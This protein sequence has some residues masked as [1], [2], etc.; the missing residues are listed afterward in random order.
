MSL[1]S[2][3]LRPL[4]V[5]HLKTAYGEL[6]DLQER[7]V[8]DF[9]D[10]RGAGNIRNSILEVHRYPPAPDELDILQRFSS[11]APTSSAR[12]PKRPLELPS[13][14]SHSYPTPSSQRIHREIPSIEGWDAE[15]IPSSERTKRHRT[16]ESKPHGTFAGHP[17][18][19]IPDSPLARDSTS[20]RGAFAGAIP[21]SAKAESPELRA[22]DPQ[23]VEK[24]DVARAEESTQTKRTKAKRA[25]LKAKTKAR[26][27]AKAEAGAKANTEA[28]ERKV[29]EENRARDEAR[30]L[31]DSE[32]KDAQK[33]VLPP[34]TAQGTATAIK[35]QAQQRIVEQEAR[36]L[37]SQRSMTPRMPGSSVTK[38]SS[39]MAS[40]RS[41]PTSNTD[42]PLRSALR[43]T[44]S[45][46]HRSVSS[47][48]FDASKPPSKT[49]TQI[50]VPKKASGREITKTPAKIGK[51]QTK[52]IV[53]REPKKLKARAV[54]PPVKPTQAAP[55]QAIVISDS[56]ASEE[57]CWQTGNA[58]A[59]PSSRKPMLPIVSQKTKPA[60]VQVLVT[61]PGIR[62]KKTQVD[63]TVAPAAL[64]RRNS[65]LDTAPMPK[66]ITRSPAQILSE[67]IS[68][69]SD[70]EKDLHAP[71]SKVLSGTK[72][73]TRVLGT[74]K[75]LSKD[76]YEVVKQPEDHLTG[77]APPQSITQ[78]PPSQ[79]RRII[80]AIADS[81]HINEAAD[82][83]LQLESQRFIPDSCVDM[84][85]SIPSVAPGDAII[86]QGLDRT[87]RLPNGIRH[88]YAADFP[89]LSVLQK[90]PRAVTPKAKP[91]MNLNSSQSVGDSPV[92][93]FEPDH[94]SS[95]GDEGSSNSDGEE[96][97][98][99]RPPQL[100]PPKPYPRV[101]K[102]AESR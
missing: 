68:I 70:S 99:R 41:S 71:T 27:K 45:S 64:P 84:A 4:K 34:R 51:V 16:H 53:T 80:P 85:S 91:K 61:P 97:I 94:S 96:D 75:K 39:L 81:E 89:K 7:V 93:K 67:T 50:P 100:V 30:K 44:P 22:S 82:R 52:L 79:S 49:P 18:S 74:M 32:S 6:L 31:A 63:R 14:P 40:L 12:P 33:S 24:V 57:P 69:S 17:N 86:N 2:L 28:Y 29:R 92:S 77:K 46:L 90:R 87:G 1:P 102:L 8:G 13:H 56:S 59:G 15:A 62:N 58:Q 36:K 72:G 95:D 42:A 60:E 23:D 78:V 21:E 5:R 43:P 3:S 37:Q 11:L 25:K 10:D 38:P 101:Q 19:A 98:D 83:Q 88:A 48:P 76:V 26:A 20:A 54:A 65:K 73:V 35:E 55:R 66:S 9:F 47:V